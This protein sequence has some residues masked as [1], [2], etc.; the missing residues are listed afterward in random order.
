MHDHPRERAEERVAERGQNGHLVLE[1]L[2]VLLAAEGVLLQDDRV[3]LLVTACPAHSDG[4]SRVEE[5]DHLEV[6]HGLSDG[7]VR[8]LG[9]GAAWQEVVEVLEVVV[10][11]LKEP[12]EL[13]AEHP[14][15]PLHPRQLRLVLGTGRSG[16]CQLLFRDGRPPPVALQLAEFVLCVVCELLQVQDLLVEA[17]ELRQV[18]LNL[19]LLAALFRHLEGE[20]FRLLLHVAQL[21][22]RGPHLVQVASHR[23]E[24]SKHPRGALA[25]QLRVLSFLPFGILL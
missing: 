6:V 4:T 3:S 10:S 19:L 1:L 22:P 13:V 17:G 12:P 11:H 20:V 2:R 16:C 23:G 8:D 14:L 21:L 24:H 15:H 5:A 25:N 18:L 7:A 9:K